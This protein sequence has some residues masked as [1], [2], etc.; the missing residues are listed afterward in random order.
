MTGGDRS[1]KS[2]LGVFSLL[3][4]PHLRLKQAGLCKMCS[5]GR[6]AVDPMMTAFRM[7]SLIAAA[8]VSFVR[9]CGLRGFEQ[10][11]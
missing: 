1:A 4:K 11:V 3:V 2:I 10:S 7:A 9:N 8:I 6:S 5:E